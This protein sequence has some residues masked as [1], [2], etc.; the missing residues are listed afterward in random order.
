MKKKNLSKLQKTSLKPIDCFLLFFLC[1][2]MVIVTAT[3][4][5][6]M[7]QYRKEQLSSLNESMITIANNQTKQFDDYLEDK[8]NLLKF[9]TQYPDIYEMD[10]SCQYAFLQHRTKQ[11][12]FNQ[13]FIVDKYG[14]GYYVSTK[15]VKDQSNEPF[16]FDIMDNEQF[17]SQPFY[18]GDS[19]IITLCTSIYNEDH[20]KVGVLCGAIELSQLCDSISESSMILDGKMYVINSRGSYIANSDSTKL[21]SYYSIFSD[22]DMQCDLIKNAFETQSS[23]TGEIMMKQISYI[24]YVRYL[25]EYEWCLVLCIPTARVFDNINRIDRL[26]KFADFLTAM[27][28]LGV[29]FIIIKWRISYK[30][31]HTDQLT[32][33]PNRLSLS[34]LMERLEKMDKYDIAILYMDLNN[35]K[36]L[37]DTYGHDFG[38]QVLC[39]FYD[40][41]SQSFGKEGFVCRMGGDEFV[42]VLVNVSE[43]QIL[44]IW[45]TVCTELADKTEHLKLSS[46]V[47]ASIGYCFRQKGEKLRLELVMDRA[48][49]NMYQ[50]KEQCKK[51]NFPPV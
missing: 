21:Q 42:S 45:E 13:L 33:A 29:V 40:V 17:I 32:M 28:I 9:L 36:Q 14:L 10:W 47:T 20:E 22:K 51:E 6:N 37:N 38:D 46:T 11:L 48:D 25:P 35:F 26:Q 5:F 31:S 30:K 7:N 50:Y 12:G 43:E 4:H 18:G 19:T 34:Y 1:L 8:M 3:I 24:T 2:S 41:L 39:I 44:S 16:F 49:K 23:L 27:G 15:T